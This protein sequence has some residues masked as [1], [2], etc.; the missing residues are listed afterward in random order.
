M[1]ILYS[2][3]NYVLNFKPWYFTPAALLD[4]PHFQSEGVKVCMFS[5]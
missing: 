2:L 4:K 3:D 5:S 1:Y